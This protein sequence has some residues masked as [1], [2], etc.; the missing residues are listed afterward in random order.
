MAVPE[1]PAA[2]VIGAGIAGMQASLDIGDAG[3]PVYLV[4]REL[5]IGGRMAQLDKTFPT[6]DCA[7]CIITPKLADVGRHPNINLVTYSEVVK[8]EGE[9]GAFRATIRHKPRYV[10][11][12]R[13]VGCGQCSQ[14]CPV[15]VPDEFNMRLDNRR[16]I[17]RLFA[18]V[19]PNVFGIERTGRAPCRDTCPTS[20]RVP[21][22]IS[23]IREGRYEDALRTIKLDNPFPG[24]CGRICPHPCE[25][26]CNRAVLDEPVN[27]KALKRFV[28]DTVYAQE[29]QQVEP[30]EPIYEER[31]AIVGAGPAGLTAAQDLT[32]AG[33]SVT[34]FDALPKAGGMLRVGVPEYRLPDEVIDREVQDIL[35]L[36]IEIKLNTRVDDV[37]SLLDDGFAAV[38]VAVGAHEGVRLPIE[39]NELDG[40]LLN[41][42]FLREVRLGE[43]AERD[44]G[45]VLVLGGGNVAVDCARTVLRLGAESVAMAC[46]EE[47]DQ[48][49]S[50]RWE[51]EGVQAEGIQIHNGRTFCRILGKDGHVTG[52]ECERVASFSFDDTGRLQLETVPD[53]KH[54]IEADTVI[55]SVGQRPCIDLCGEVDLST[56]KM[57]AVDPETCMTSREG[58]FAAGDVV[59]GTAFA[60]DAIAAGH[61]V[62][63]SIHHFLREKTPVENL[64]DRMVDGWR[65]FEEIELPIIEKTVDEVAHLQQQSR[66]DQIELE[67]EHVDRP[68]A[69]LEQPL[70]EEQARA[71]ASRCLNCGVCAECLQCLTACE[72]N[73][74][75]HNQREWEEELEVGAVV[76]ATGFDPYDARRKPN[77]GYGKYPNVIH[78]LE[79]ERLFSASGPT[80][81]TLQLKDGTIPKDVVF[82][83]C[84]GSRDLQ[85]GSN[86]YCSRVCCMYTAKLAHLTRERIHDA[87]I[88]V[89]YIDIRAFGKGFEEFHERVRQERVIYRRGNVSEVIKGPNGRLIVKAEDTLLA[90]P[91]EVE[92]DLVILAT[93]LV[94]RQG[95][96]EIA[97]T[98][99]LKIGPDGFFQEAH[100][101]LDPCGS[102]V[103]GIF[104]GGACQGPKDILD[105]VA[106]AKAAA[107]SA[108]VV[109]A[110]SSN[111]RQELKPAAD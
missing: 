1:K 61:R 40:V 37:K 101:K 4:E 35:D 97:E 47:L 108:L 17:Y 32:L 99:G 111:Q 68:F 83:Q 43:F 30:V 90:K 6:L 92:A 46:L 26:S 60:V 55:F 58:I 103:P 87:N 107:A 34:V 41:T 102:G 24:I 52:V 79:S 5:G 45:R 14:V 73:A 65:R 2:L 84:V 82:I 64:E 59:T 23:L 66:I 71:E 10:D 13:C 11:L 27:I 109:L 98:L 78:A 96:L 8:I 20:Q 89:F 29:R 19:V 28:A 15:P 104:L 31:V 39:G 75:D 88:T 48:M 21:G 18:Q 91:V 50:H 93:A 25:T 44:L 9:P 76:V 54:V 16:A 62:A 77:L 70:T 57:L 33:Y 38:L 100:A 7:S 106:Q 51:I 12:T 110:Q 42:D 67:L 53:S 95:T 56:R 86:P 3:F 74:I 94:P 22:Y 49:P 105:S 36:G 80:T 63:R 85:E 69:E 81:G 72:A